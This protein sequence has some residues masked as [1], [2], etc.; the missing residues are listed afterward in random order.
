MA[1]EVSK[2]TS[3]VSIYLSQLQQDGIVS[4]RLH[5]R[6]KKF[7]LLKKDL[8]DKTIEDHVPRFWDRPAEGFA[9]MVNS[10]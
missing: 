8:I 2:A 9:D 4:S 1:K 5:N 6:K 10:L 7:G 3:T